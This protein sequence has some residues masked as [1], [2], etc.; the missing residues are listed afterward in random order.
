MKKFLLTL[1][2]AGVAYG[3]QAQLIVTE[4]GQI[5]A[6]NVLSTTPASPTAT[7][8]IWGLGA[9]S[10]PG[11]GGSITFG[12]GSSCGI[13]GDGGKGIM[14]WKADNGFEFIS[15]AGKAAMTYSTSG[16]SLLFSS[17]LKAPSFITTSDARLKANIDEI[18]DSYLGLLVLTPISYELISQESAAIEIEKD[19][20][21]SDFDA[22]TGTDNRT[23]FGFIAQE[24]REIYPNLVVEDEEGML[25][26]DYTGFIPLLVDAVR[27]LTEQVNRQQ[28]T[29]AMLTG[30]PAPAMMAAGVQTTG[31][32]QSSLKQN[33]PNPFNTSTV[34]ECTLADDVEDAFICIYDLQ[35]KQMKRIGLSERGSVSCILDAST[36]QPGMYI[37]ALI[38]DGIE[39]DSKR[40]ILTD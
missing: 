1:V 38:A 21:F 31:I 2:A 37:Y 40:M 22:T 19:K 12:P 28:E 33:R 23:R 11:S 4:S 9:V 30:A 27:N 18:N 29:I 16:N 15:G 35:G 36:L 24:V 7:L 20:E 17:N 8:N 13:N 34:I 14:T 3:T 25:G 39:I 5:Q 32:I 26:I 6:G 10:T